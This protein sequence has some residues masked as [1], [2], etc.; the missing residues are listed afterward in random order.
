M[1]NFGQD[2]DGVFRT[3]FIAF[4]AT[5][6]AVSLF[7]FFIYRQR[8]WG[9]VRRVLECLGSAMGE[10]ISDTSVNKARMMLVLCA[11]MYGSNFVGSKI[12]QEHLAPSLI[13]AFRFLIGSVFYMNDVLNYRGDTRVIKEGL[14][15]GFWCS[16]GFMVQSITL[17]YTTANKNAFLCAL[18][19]VI[20]PIFESIAGCLTLCNAAPATQ[21]SASTPC[22]NLHTVFIPALLSVGGIAALELGGLD[23]PKWV[24]AVVLIAP[25]AFAMGFYRTE[26]FCS[27]QSDNPKVR[28]GII[29][30]T[31]AVLCFGFA[32]VTGDLSLSVNALSE[33]LSVLLKWEVM[34]GLLYAGIFMTAWSS[35]A[36]QRS[37][38]VLS[39]AEAT[40]IYS[41]EPLFATVLSCVFLHEYFGWNSAVGAACIVL[42]CIWNSVVLPYF[43]QVRTLV[44]GKRIDDIAKV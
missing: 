38:K 27:L 19:V 28:S 8:I 26:H 11:A 18:S 34:S 7:L 33:L 2:E 13:T 31:T 24:D 9:C 17:L 37:L 6:L 25:L 3:E 12:L 39:A 36:E 43:E 5:V 16:L 10:S 32:I 40:V 20:I 29:I 14:E 21:S 42:A 30:M 22:S 1:E 35:F 15:L 44:S 41:L 4:T 23:P